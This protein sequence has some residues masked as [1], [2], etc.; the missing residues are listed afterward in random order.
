MEAT[1]TRPLLDQLL[2][3]PDRQRPRSVRIV[4]P[5]PE[6]ASVTVRVHA[7]SG[8]LLADLV[9]VLAPGEGLEL[10]LAPLIGLH[11]GVVAVRVSSTLP[12]GA[13]AALST[14]SSRVY[15]QGASATLDPSSRRVAAHAPFLGGQASGLLL[16]NPNSEPIRVTVTLANADGGPILPSLAQPSTYAVTIASNG[17]VSLNAAT[18][19]GLPFSPTVDGI[20]QVD[21]PEVPLS[22]VFLIAQGDSLSAYPLSASPVSRSYYAR[23]GGEP[24]DST[25]LAVANLDPAPSGVEVWLLGSRGESLARQTVPLGARSKRSMLLGS[26]FDPAVLARARGIVIESGGGFSSILAEGVS[27]PDKAVVRPR[28]TA[29]IPPPPAAVPAL[30]SVEPQT[31]RPGTILRFR[32][33]NIDASTVLRFAGFDLFPR[34]G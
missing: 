25:G 31:V 10:P 6:T 21:S 16:G 32:A 29:W 4:N 3:V 5:N 17:A 24:P 2:T 1:G 22:A 30:F 9:Q 27:S 8:V 11:R 7:G 28:P 23:R 34:F 20:I 33:E 26:L 19:A 15:I 12:V 18:I 14:P 13:E